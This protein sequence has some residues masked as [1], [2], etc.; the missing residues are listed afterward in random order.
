MPKQNNKNNAVSLDALVY[1]LRNH[2]VVGASVI[3]ASALRLQQSIHEANQNLEYRLHPRFKKSEKAKNV[4]QAYYRFIR[5]LKKAPRET[6]YFA[7]SAVRD[8][9]SKV[10]KIQDTG[11]LEI[12]L[13]RDL[14]NIR[15]T[16]KRFFYSTEWIGEE[17]H[18][19][20]F[21]NVDLPLP[22][23]KN[24]NVA[25]TSEGTVVYS[26]Q[27]ILEMLCYGSIMDEL[28]FADCW[29]FIR[30][31]I[32]GL[33]TGVNTFGNTVN[34]TTHYTVTK[35]DAMLYI[36]DVVAK[37]AARQFADPTEKGMDYL[38]AAVEKMCSSNDA[39]LP[40]RLGH[41]YSYALYRPDRGS[42]NICSKKSNIRRSP[43]LRMLFDPAY[44]DAYGAR[45]RNPIQQLPYDYK[46]TRGVQP[47]S[48][49]KP[50]TPWYKRFFG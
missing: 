1:H 8:I 14:Q 34:V 22:Y 40:P 13:Q 45:I 26:P 41:S 21:G 20:N 44:G 35:E 10:S 36:N 24:L 30:A 2:P 49:L 32:S 31:K 25:V 37:I 28:G 18:G 27:P 9:R 4:L 6:Q 50:Q 7:S 15:E 16:G 39:P 33:K 38:H 3:G 46:V 29:E 11:G 12:S 42:E 19:F 5:D 43:R 47:S 17:K 48:D 23:S